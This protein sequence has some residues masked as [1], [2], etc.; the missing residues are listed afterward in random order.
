MDKFEYEYTAVPDDERQEIERIRALYAPA[1]DRTAKIEKLKDLNARARRP[2]T[3]AAITLGVIGTIFF[4]LGMCLSI[5]WN[6][7]VF[8]IVLGLCGIAILAVTLPV[9]SHL[10]KKG[11]EKYGKEILKLSDELLN[12]KHRQP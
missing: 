12:E 6:E 8:G 11:K 1:D 7:L 9:H 5:E 2:A 4:G 10:L 3:I